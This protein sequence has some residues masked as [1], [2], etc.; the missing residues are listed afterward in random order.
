M[1]PAT[2]GAVGLQCL[3]QLLPHRADTIW[4]GDHARLE[5]LLHKTCQNR[6]LRQTHAAPLTSALWRATHV[7]ERRAVAGAGVIRRQVAS[8][9]LVEVTNLAAL[10]C[11]YS[12]CCYITNLFCLDFWVLGWAHFRERGFS[13]ICP[14]LSLSSHLSSLPMGVLSR[15]YGNKKKQQLKCNKMLE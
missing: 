4:H 2:R 12:V 1:R 10:F 8:E 6:G 3:V 13:R 15:A 11:Y 14:P 9:L 7:G 5:T